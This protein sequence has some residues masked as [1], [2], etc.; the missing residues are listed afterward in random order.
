[1]A[2][3]TIWHDDYWLLLM[4]IYMK[5]PVGVKPI[6]DRDMVELSLELHIAPEALNVRMQQLASLQTP[7]IR[8]YWKTYGDKPKRLTRAV[9]LLRQMK[10]FGTAGDFFEGVDI[11]E[12]FEKD[13]RPLAEDPELTPVMLI[14]LLDLY[15]HLTP[16][17]MVTQ[18]PEVQQT[19]RLLKLHPEKVIEILDIYQHCDPYLNRSDVVFSALY[20]PCQQVWQR[21]G[22]QEPTVVANHAK[23]LKA[24]FGKG[25]K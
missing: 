18:T 1:M 23:E 14:I 8:Y 16:I 17:T 22:N 10:G 13:F 25:K 21:F 9:K 3:N 20:L 19:A 11:Q 24:F 12:T 7:R 6:Y 2:K 5:K 4:Q 15:F